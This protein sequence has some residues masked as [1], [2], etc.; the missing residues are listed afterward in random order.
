[1]MNAIGIIFSNIHDN[2]LPEFTK[3]RTFGAVPFGG[4]Y[5]LIDFVLSNM[6]NSGITTVG[7]VARN[8]YHSLTS[9]L[10]SGKEWDLSRKFGGLTIYPPYSTADGRSLY[11]GRLEALKNVYSYIARAREDYVVLSDCDVVCNMDYGEVL[12]FHEENGA[13]I[14]AVYRKADISSFS[15]ETPV[16]YTLTDGCRVKTRV[17]GHP[18]GEQNLSMSMWLLKKDLLLRIIDEALATGLRSF[19]RDILAVN[20]ADMK[21]VGYEFTGYA[22]QIVSTADFFKAHLELLNRDVRRELCPKDRPIY[23]KVYD[24][25]P[26]RYLDGAQVKNS[27]VANGAVIMGNVE[28]CIIGRDVYI[29]KNTTVKNSVL[30][31][32]AVVNEGSTVNNCILDKKTVVRPNQTLSGTEN[33]PFVAVKGSVI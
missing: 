10:G 9:H 2:H 31:H 12:R 26:A 30:M 20:A 4:R 14:T 21:I 27:L 22:R 19:E 16:T 5:R 32:G 8:N 17:G 18:T 25:P 3:A 28:N 15:G 1:M 23:T 7:V 33:Y 11:T 6:T 13:D 24:A 29:A